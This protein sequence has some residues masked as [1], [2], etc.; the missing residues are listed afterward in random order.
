MTLSR[1]WLLVVASVG[2]MALVG[3]GPTYP[4]CETDE[5]CAKKSEVCVNG[6]CKQCRDDSQCNQNDACG[7]CQA[8][9]TC[10]RRAGCCTSDIDCPRGKCWKQAGQTAGECGALCDDTHP[11]PAGQICKS[12]VCEPGVECSDTV[13][14]PPGK[15]CVNG[16]C[17]VTCTLQAVTFDYN[18]S[19]IRSDQ[20]VT[21][22]AN[23]DCVKAKGGS[24]RVDGH[25][26]ERGEEEY[27]IALS[28]RRATAVRKYYVDLGIASSSIKINSYG[29]SK[30]T[31]SESH[32][33]CW[34]QNRRA[35]THFE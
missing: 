16:E 34:D 35:E 10:G 4:K 6:L 7:Q 14:C 3:C 15:E 5:H 24:I 32:E 22:K 21:L 19:L 11:C 12:G 8:D 27:N 28:E 31:C 13:P 18:E 26:D 23:A 20:E 9:G 30:P 1:L 2:L 33:P 17:K 25:S 29:F